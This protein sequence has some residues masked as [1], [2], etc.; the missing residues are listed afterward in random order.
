MQKKTIFIKIHK[1]HKIIVF[2]TFCTLRIIIYENEENLK[3]LN[4]SLR[5]FSWRYVFENCVENDQLYKFLG[6]FFFKLYIWTL[7][8]Y[9]E[10]VSSKCLSWRNLIKIII[11]PVFALLSLTLLYF[12]KLYQTYQLYI[13]YML[14]SLEK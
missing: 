4:V 3:H 13:I 8:S 11:S 1:M 12:P 7:L 14:I 9:G 2:C 5:T 10:L 6:N